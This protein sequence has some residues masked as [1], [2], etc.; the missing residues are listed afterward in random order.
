M[1]VD[2]YENRFTVTATLTVI[3]QQVREQLTGQLALSNE[4][5][6]NL[7]NNRQRKR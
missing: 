6:S 2:A 5:L 3:S 7:T 4:R 1:T